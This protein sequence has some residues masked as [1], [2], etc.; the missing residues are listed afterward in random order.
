M[1]DAAS[2]TALEARMSSYPN[3]KREILGWRHRMEVENS[4]SASFVQGF[5]QAGAG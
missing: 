1:F 5:L 2:C 3:L 4:R